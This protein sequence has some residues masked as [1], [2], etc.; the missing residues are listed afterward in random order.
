MSK[1]L[2]EPMRSRLRRD[3]LATTQRTKIVG[4]YFL[5]PAELSEYLGIDTKTLANWRS[6]GAG[7]PYERLG[8]RIRYPK[9][10]IES[11]RQK[12]RY[13][14]TRQWRDAEPEK[15]GVT[16]KKHNGPASREQIIAQIIAL[17][18]QLDG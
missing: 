13:T 18:R 2:R 16:A 4:R 1:V 11:W 14:S 17:V 5:T 7:P 15:K 6:G 8:N 9:D 10:E 3:N 12:N